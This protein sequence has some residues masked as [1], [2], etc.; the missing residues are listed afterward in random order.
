MGP[1]ICEIAPGET[2]LAT[3]AARWL[4]AFYPGVRAAIEGD[5]ATVSWPAHVQERLARRWQ[6]AVINE[7]LQQRGAAARGAILRKLLA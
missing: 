1:V 4:E 6:S 2:A 3:T 7:R 5:R